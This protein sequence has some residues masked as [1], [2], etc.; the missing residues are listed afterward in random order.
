MKRR[1]RTARATALPPYDREALLVEISLFPDW[2]GGH[3]GEPAFP[4]ERRDEFLAD[5][6]K[7]LELVE[8][9]QDDLDAARF[10]FAE[11]PLAGGRERHRAASASSISR[12]R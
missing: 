1:F 11:H 8:R 6:S 9:A 3:G 2:F 12:T 7:M 10:P 5:W 4:K